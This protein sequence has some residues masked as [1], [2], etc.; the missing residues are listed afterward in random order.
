MHR[1]AGVGL[2]LAAGLVLTAAPALGD[3]EADGPAP[4]PT[5]DELLRRIERL[6]EDK[7][8]MAGEIDELRTQLG[9]SWLTEQRAD[10][11]R[12][13]VADVLADAD[14]RAGQLGN[15]MTAGWDEHFFLASPDGRFRLQIDGMLQVRWLWNY[16][17]QVDR[18]RSGFENTRNKL[19]FRGH[20]FSRDITYL[21]RTDF[22]RG[23]DDEDLLQDAWVRYHLNDEFSIRLGQFKLPF[24]R[25][26]LVSPGYQQAVERSLVNESLNLGRSQGIELLY[27]SRSSRFAFVFSDA[28]TDNVGGFNLVGTDPQN[29]PWSEPL[30]E[31]ALTARYEHLVAGSWDQFVQLTSPSGEDFALLLGIA[32][33]YQKDESTGAPSFARDEE[34]WV[35]V[36]T[37]VS[38]QFGGANL[39]GSFIYHYIDDPT[40]GFFHF[41]GAVLQGGT[42]FTEKFEAF[43][44]LEY[45]YIDSDFEFDDLWVLTL[46]G[47][48]YF[49]GQD[50]KLTADIGFGLNTISS[51]WDS[52]IAGWRVESPGVEPQ[53]VIRT[54]LQLLF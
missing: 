30:A 19:T 34:E 5:I 9:D 25:E 24:N 37:D 12:A 17:D 41:F 54:Q 3:E 11:I 18:Y 49:D 29:T 16:H 47:N 44:R 13:L 40:F 32:G 28:G 50:M 6:E 15:G 20:V 36:A 38:A 1:Q 8:R 51:A 31:W 2:T 4:E 42:Y 21:V 22:G 23:D 43:A 35:A 10:E 52:D 14:T 33:H 48:Y 27:T 46:G 45:G 53:V 26:E 7:T 39:F